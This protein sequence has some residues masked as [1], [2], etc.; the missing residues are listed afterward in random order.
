MGLSIF[1][2][3]QVLGHV[4]GT[5][6]QTLAFDGFCIIIIYRLDNLTLDCKVKVLDGLEF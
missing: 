3:K 4:G 1:N 6:Y 5:A 2:T